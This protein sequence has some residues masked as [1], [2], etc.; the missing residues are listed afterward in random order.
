MLSSACKRYHQKSVCPLLRPQLDSATYNPIRYITLS[1]R[2]QGA[3][4]NNP[5]DQTAESQSEEF[6]LE[7]LID[8][9]ADDLSVGDG[10]TGQ[11]AL[12]ASDATP[13]G[14]A[15]CS[16]YPVDPM[17]PDFSPPNGGDEPRPLAN[18]MNDL[19]ALSLPEQSPILLQSP[20]GPMP[21]IMDPEILPL[22]RGEPGSTAVPNRPGNPPRQITVSVSKPSVETA[23]LLL[24]IAYGTGCEKSRLKV[25][26]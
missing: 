26:R 24:E 18:S 3:S 2:Q 9:P 14:N 5:N 21:S 13:A 11:E 7:D 25:K 4:N 1:R 20:F 10:G 16:W 12:N 19:T 15:D 17:M 6:D 22:G 8:S 23:N